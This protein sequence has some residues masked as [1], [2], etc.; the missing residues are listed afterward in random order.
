MPLRSCRAWTL[1]TY[2]LGEADLI[3]VFFTL[4]HG[5]VRSVARGARRVRSRF[6]SA[7]QL[8]T[9]TRLVFFEKEGRDL[10]RVSECEVDR[11]YYHVLLTPE[12]AA[13]AAYFAELV[14]EFTA[15]RAPEP[16]LF[17]LLGATME[18]MAAGVSGALLARY[19][20]VWVLRLSG[21]LPRL[22]VCGGC[23]RR[24]GDARWVVPHPLEFV[25][26]QCRG[27]RQGSR[28]LSPE[29]TALLA[30]ILRKRPEEVADAR[31]WR[32]GAVQRLAAV[33]RL[34]IQGQLDRTLRSVRYVDRLRRRRR[35][36]TARGASRGE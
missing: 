7:F 12:A 2:P 14:Q 5:Q 1:R 28:W 22:G 8:L 4:E 33:N 29:G 36:A 34:L 32:S 21:V 23:G 9:L 19:F 10:T 3:V 27:T 25:C 30:E 16:A 24:L 35:R 6:G 15:E 13:T 17:R 26:R 20:E 18:A 11:S 31:R